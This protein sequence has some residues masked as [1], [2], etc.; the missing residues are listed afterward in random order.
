MSS[1]D[2]IKHFIHLYGRLALVTH[3]SLS[4]IFY[5]GFFFLVNNK[6]IDH[7]KLLSKFG[8]NPSNSK[9]VNTSGDAAVAYVLYKATM[10]IRLSI[11][12]VT[13]PI[14]AKILKRK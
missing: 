8:I 7:Q 13:V 9:L 1:K 12:G 11:T 14:I 5:G 3:I 4:L 10:P 2:K 6:I